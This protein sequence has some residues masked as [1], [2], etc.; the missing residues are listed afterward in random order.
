M[1]DALT[2]SSAPRFSTSSEGESLADT[3]GR[4]TEA[5]ACDL[6][7]VLDQAEEYFLYHAEETGFARELPDLV[8]RPGLRVRVLLALATTRSPSS[9]GSRGGSRTCSRT[10]FGSTISTGA[11]PERRSPSRSSATTRPPASRSRSSPS[12]SRPS[13][14]RPR[15][16]RS[17]SARR[18]AGSRPAKT[19][20]SRVE[21]PYLQL[22]MER[23]WDEEHEQ[24]SKRL[25]LETLR[26]TRRS[27]GD[28]AGPPAAGCRRS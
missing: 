22:V 6:L 3:L 12:W 25:R 23:V 1:R 7:L 16:G 24:G 4:W 20:E 17:T 27:R 21:A 10:T 28:R 26:P 11:P 8:T 15:P 14:T 9:T 2:A 19:D 18:A 13:S 5:L